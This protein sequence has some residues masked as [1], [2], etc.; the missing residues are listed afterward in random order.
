MIVA[1][2]DPN[3]VDPLVGIERLDQAHAFAAQLRIVGI[4]E[5]IALVGAAED[6]A[7]GVDVGDQNLEIEPTALECQV[8][9]RRLD[10]N[11]YVKLI[12]R[13]ANDLIVYF[14]LQFVHLVTS[15]EAFS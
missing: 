11:P 5:P 13:S 14:R 12:R 15:Q 9:Y 10:A 6:L 8:L 2:G 3:P 7:L 1:Q 4:G